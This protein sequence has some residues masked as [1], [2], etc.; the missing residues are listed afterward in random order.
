MSKSSVPVERRDFLR[1]SALAAIATT[2]DVSL[3]ESRSSV[4]ATAPL[5]SRSFEP[6]TF[7]LEETTIGANNF[8]K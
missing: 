1:A 5:N 3:G 2:L 8:R 7:E 4:P 6:S